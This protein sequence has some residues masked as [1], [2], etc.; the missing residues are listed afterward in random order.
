MRV[1]EGIQLNWTTSQEFNNSGFA[2]ERSTDGAGWQQIG[3]VPSAARGGNSQ[4]ALYYQFV[5]RT[6]LTGLNQYRLKQVDIDNRHEYSR[7]ISI[8]YEDGRRLFLSPNPTNSGITIVSGLKEGD[9]L[10]LFTQTGK[11]IYRYRATTGQHPINLKAQP[12]GIY[13]LE[14]SNGNRREV[15]KIIRQ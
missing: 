10:R 15:M 12:A 14:V 7:T 2:I 5:D 4:S 13:Y 1:E 3:F 9:D 11:I 8:R 6:P